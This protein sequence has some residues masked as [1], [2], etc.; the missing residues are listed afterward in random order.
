MRLQ[1][2]AAGIQRPAAGRAT[3]PAFEVALRLGAAYN[4]VSDD[5]H[6]QLR[7]YSDALGV[8]YQIRDDVEDLAAG[9]A[10][11]DL[12]AMRPTLPLAIA[13]ERASGDSKQ[14]LQRAW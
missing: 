2:D 14:M 12:L 7:R 4:G 9:H 10:P 3:S 8:A 11:D 1:S 6:Q 13:Y 5:V